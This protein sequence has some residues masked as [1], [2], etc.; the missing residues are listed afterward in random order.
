MGFF[1]IPRMGLC[2]DHQ[3]NMDDVPNR[4]LAPNPGRRL[5]STLP[6]VP[7]WA[8]SSPATAPPVPRL[9][10]S[11]ATRR[12]ASSRPRSSNASRPLSSVCPRTGASAPSRRSWSFISRAPAAP[13][14]W[15]GTSS[16]QR[17]PGARLLAALPMLA[18]AEIRVRTGARSRN[19]SKPASRWK[20]ESRVLAVPHNGADGYPAFQFDAANLGSQSRD[21]GQAD[22]RQQASSRSRA[23]PR[24]SWNFLAARLARAS[25]SISCA[26]ASS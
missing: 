4:R 17:P 23:G 26:T 19:P 18:A 11:S 3:T 10:S 6:T 5:P 16:T 13:R 25:S 24:C 21:G 9:C 2:H 22:P 8:T 1:N 14:T 12:Q 15:N 20:R 7:P